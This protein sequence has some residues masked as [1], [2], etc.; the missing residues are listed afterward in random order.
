MVDI[1]SSISTALD[2][3]KKL[4]ALNKAVGE[5]DF[6]ILLANLTGELGDAKLEAAN[7]KIELAESKA[8]ADNLQ[9]Q[10]AQRAAA[11]PQFIDS[12]YVFDESG[13]HY[14]TGCYDTQGRKVLLAEHTGAF[15][16]FGR[17]HCPACEEHFG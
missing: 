12:S 16:A 14:C 13:R 8:H 9:R 11:E 2:I 17:W 4:R 15:T 3:V 10:V 1:V 5:A 6:K 7:L